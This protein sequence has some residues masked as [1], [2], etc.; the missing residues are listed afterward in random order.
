[1]KV[2]GDDIDDTHFIETDTVR[3]RTERIE[4]SQGDDQQKLIAKMKSRIQTI[5]HDVDAKKP[6][7]VTWELID[8]GP[9]G[10]EFRRIDGGEIF[11]RLV[12]RETDSASLNVWSIGLRSLRA[13]FP[14]S[15]FEEDSIL[16]DFLRVVR[17]MEQSGD[18]MLDVDS[19]LP[20]TRAAKKLAERLRLETPAVR[21][22]LLRDV[23]TMGVDMLSGER[24]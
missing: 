8:D 23:T 17:D 7:L 1:V 4:V 15:L 2:T 13:S 5:R 20:D 11:L 10:R 22:Q 3:Y 14:S 16:G 24:S 6:L 19:Y 12:R 18:R 9:L 21:R